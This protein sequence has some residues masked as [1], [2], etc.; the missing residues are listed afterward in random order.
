VKLLGDEGGVLAVSGGQEH[1][2]FRE[3]PLLQEHL[4]SALG[5]DE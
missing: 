5:N 3:Q 2:S 1:Q 4:D